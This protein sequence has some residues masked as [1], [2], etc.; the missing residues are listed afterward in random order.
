MVLKVFYFFGRLQTSTFNLITLDLCFSHPPSPMRDA[1]LS[2]SYLG[3]R[4]VGLTIPIYISLCNIVNV[5]CW[6]FSRDSHT[7][8]LLSLLLSSTGE[9]NKLTQGKDGACF[10]CLNRR[11]FFGA[12][13][14]MKMFYLS[15]II[16]YYYYYLL[17]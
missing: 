4:V 7:G 3:G 14:S 2:Y 10:T 5:K 11:R 12:E 6:L 8:D 1:W 15:T 13:I 17:I 16:Y 9:F